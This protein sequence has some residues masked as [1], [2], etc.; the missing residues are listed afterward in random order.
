MVDTTVT[1]GP[2]QL[3]IDA[4][5]PIFLLLTQGSDLVWLALPVPDPSLRD[6]VPMAGVMPDVRPSRRRVGQ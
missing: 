4:G 6:S 2:D 1:D 3:H 5:T